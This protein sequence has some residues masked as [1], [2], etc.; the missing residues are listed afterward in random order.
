[1][2]WYARQG[3]E[4]RRAPD[5][6]WP[7]KDGKDTEAGSR[8]WGQQKQGFQSTVSP[9]AQIRLLWER[10]RGVGAR[11]RVGVR[12]LWRVGQRDARE[13]FQRDGSGGH[14]PCPAGMGSQP[15]SA[16]VVALTEKGGERDL[17]GA[18][19]KR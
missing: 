7:G 18:N 2:S 14:Q 8:E 11:E 13:D 15:W 10:Q 17:V 12:F 9:G 6:P 19:E 16:T 5:R 1:M 4:L 3:E